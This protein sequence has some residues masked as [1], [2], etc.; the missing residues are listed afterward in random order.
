LDIPGPAGSL[1][2]LLEWDPERPVHL[3]AVVCH[4]HPQYGGTMHTKVVYRAAKAAIELGIPTLRFNFRGVG[5]SQGDFDEGRGERDDLRAALDH[6]ETRFPGTRTC[7]IGFSFGAWVGLEVGSRDSRAC[8]LVGIG[9][10]AG[11]EEPGF[12]HSAPKPKLIVQGTN[13]P[14]GPRAQIEELFASLTEPKQLR[15]IEGADH[16]FT[17]RLDEV[18]S[19]LRSF[20]QEA[21]PQLVQGAG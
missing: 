19:T 21:F 2:A 3:T 5:K 17:G 6:L 18:Q 13:D 4:P 20:L 15:W 7:V 8:A 12:L 9:V 16:F 14:F 10:P 1:E 11:S